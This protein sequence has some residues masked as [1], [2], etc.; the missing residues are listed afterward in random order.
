MAQHGLHLVERVHGKRARLSDIG[1]ARRQ[2]LGVDLAPDRQ[3]GAVAA[4]ARDLGRRGDFRH[5]D[6]YLVAELPCR[7]GH[8]RAVIAAGRGC[9][10][11]GRNLAHQQI[12][13]SAARLE[14]ARVLRQLELEVQGAPGEAEVLCP[15]REDRRL[16][17]VRRYALVGGGDCVSRD[18]AGAGHGITAPA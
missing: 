17:D 14:G 12:G 15:H 5:E 18:G 8:R 1:L 13:E 6:A 2:R 7:V 3:V 4:D 16:P 10:A 11:G 9:N